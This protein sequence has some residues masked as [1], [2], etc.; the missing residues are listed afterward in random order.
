M[1]MIHKTVLLKKV[2]VNR[3]LFFRMR[4][5][6]LRQIPVYKSVQQKGLLRWPTHT[7]KHS[8][9]ILYA[10]DPL[11]E[12]ETPKRAATTF[13]ISILLRGSRLPSGWGMQTGTGTV[14]F[15]QE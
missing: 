7:Y 5:A 9:E 4:I 14:M 8:I 12:A 15:N 13:E 11:N 1:V 10:F 2:Y 3:L 6:F